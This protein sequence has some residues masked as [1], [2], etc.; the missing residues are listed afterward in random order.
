LKNWNSQSVRCSVSDPG[1][2]FIRLFGDY[3]ITTV[4]LKGQAV[5][6]IQP[7]LNNNS[8]HLKQ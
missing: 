5:F 6:K 4:P 2:K 3:L 7:A 1:E 8:G